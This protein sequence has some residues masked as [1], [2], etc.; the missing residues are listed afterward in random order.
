MDDR[1]EVKLDAN[2]MLFA[3]DEAR[4]GVGT[5]PLH[6]D[7]HEEVSLEKWGAGARVELNAENGI[8]RKSVV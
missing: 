2:Q 4:K 7:E 1:T 5:M 3:D 6:S 8:D